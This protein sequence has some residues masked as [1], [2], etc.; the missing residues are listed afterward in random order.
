MRDKATVIAELK[1]AVKEWSAKA[2]EVGDC[3][4]LQGWAV[5]NANPELH[6]RL[7]RLSKEAETLGITPDDL[8]LPKL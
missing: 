4:G 2:D 6:K 8:K 1:A 7:Q 3:G 5:L